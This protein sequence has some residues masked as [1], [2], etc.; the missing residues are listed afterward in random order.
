M[1]ATPK[2]GVKSPA[3]QFLRLNQIIP[4]QV[5][6]LVLQTPSLHV[7][8]GDPNRSKPVKQAKFALAPCV[9]SDPSRVALGGAR[10]RGHDIS[11]VNK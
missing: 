2:A 7:R 11:S 9:V 1:H 3:D 8:V 4:L 6:T 10:R 5:G